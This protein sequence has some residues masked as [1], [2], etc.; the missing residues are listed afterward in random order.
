MYKAYGLTSHVRRL[1]A[2]IAEDGVWCFGIENLVERDD[3]EMGPRW[4]RILVV[5][6]RVGE[7]KLGGRERG[8]VWTRLG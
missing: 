1:Q 5:K 2:S 4:E 7:G 6:G 3:T 8:R